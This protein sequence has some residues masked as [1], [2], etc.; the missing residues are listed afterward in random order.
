MIQNK[1]LRIAVFP[2]SIVS[3]WNHGNAH[4]LRG[5]IR[6]LQ[7]MGH[8]VLSFEEDGNW[9]LSNL[10]RDHGLIPIQ[11]FK[12]RFS[13]IE[14]RSYE[15]NG[16]ASLYSWL[17]ELVAD[18]DVCVVH[19]WNHPHLVRAIGEVAGQTGTVSLFHDTHHRA[20]T[21]PHRLDAMGLESYSAVLAY[22]P[23]IADIYRSLLPEVEAIVFHEGA[24]TDLFR[25][26]DCPKRHDVLFIGNW[27]DEDR[28]DTT[29]R[30][31]IEPGRALPHLSFALFGVRYPEDVLRAIRQAGIFWGGWLPNYSAPEAYAA[32]KLTVH[33]PRREYV[34]ALHGTPTIR[35][36]EALACGVPL[37]SA[38]WRDESNLF[39][40]GSDYVAVD[41][42][43][44][45]IEAVRWL[46]SDAAAR[47]RI[48]S[49]GR[50][51]ILKSHTCRH[52]AE[53][54]VRIVRRLQR[55]G[56]QDE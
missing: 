23:A 5:L 52:R 38:G 37:V 41:S 32:S 28:N 17:K 34:E 16:R 15:L 18:V 31:F 29:I 27:G 55:G 8:Q 7:E 30:Y 26:L 21:E 1:P 56:G 11:E 20:L 6:N 3:D 25:P 44:Q 49:Q 40:D 45:M 51:T 19:E 36:F 14:H 39:E 13:F 22:G 33:I 50:A 53:E 10:V 4:F 48:G 35:I 46:A 9:S 2:H 54:L 24:D 42:Q 12:R 43:A 47:S